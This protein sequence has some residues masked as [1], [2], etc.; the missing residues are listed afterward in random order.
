MEESIQNILNEDC[1]NNANVS[2]FVNKKLNNFKPVKNIKAVPPELDEELHE[3]ISLEEKVVKEIDPEKI[4]ENSSEI[5]IYF[6]KNCY[7]GGHILKKKK[8]KLPKVIGPGPVSTTLKLG[9]TLLINS[10]Y[11]PGTALKKLKNIQNMLFNGPGGVNMLI[12]S[13]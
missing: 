5:C 11:H 3:A 1:I 4:K 12:I 2:K 7:S 6:N 8:L 13:K 10:D 9:I